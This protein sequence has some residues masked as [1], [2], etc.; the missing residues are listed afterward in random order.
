MRGKRYR[1]RRQWYNTHAWAYFSAG[2]LVA[3]GVAAL[4]TGRFIY[5]I[6]ALS[7]AIV[8]M[9]VAYVR[10]RGEECLYILDDREVQ[11]RNARSTVTIPLKEVVDASLVD[12]SAARDYIVQRARRDLPSD[13]G[14]AAVRRHEALFVRFCSVD[15][16]L[17]T[18]TFGLG[19]RMIDRMPNAKNDL[20][21]LRLRNGEEYVLSP[22]YNQDLV[23]NLSRATREAGAV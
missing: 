22:L 5:P 20:V 14:R 13:P 7:I 17:R 11:L 4:T 15:I 9:V 10:D 2:L 23:T 18:L 6:L 3:G 12:R 21:L 19:R 1:S 8:G 16:G